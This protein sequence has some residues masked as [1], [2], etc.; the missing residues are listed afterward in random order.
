M[1]WMVRMILIAGLGW[2]VGGCSGTAP[3]L[4]GP[5]AVLAPASNGQLA[6]LPVG[7]DRGDTRRPPANPLATRVFASLAI[8]RATGQAVDRPF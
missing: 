5:S 7:A 6:S 3:T 8:E 4:S 2:A 1:A